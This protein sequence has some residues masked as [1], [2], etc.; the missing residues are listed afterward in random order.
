MARGL[1]WSGT[2]PKLGVDRVARGVL[3]STEGRKKSRPLYVLSQRG[4]PS[5]EQNTQTNPLDVVDFGGQHTEGRGSPRRG[6][7]VDR[8][9]DVADLPRR[10]PERSC[11]RPEHTVCTGEY[12]RRHERVN[13]RINSPEWWF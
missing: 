11:Q 12:D 10:E 9:W 8:H 4:T 3:L 13:P 2:Q 1:P 6:G 5:C 7:P